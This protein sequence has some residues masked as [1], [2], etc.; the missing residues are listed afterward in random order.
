M[1]HISMNRAAAILKDCDGLLIYT[2][3]NP[4]GD[5]L[6]SA[7]A[8]CLALREMGKR[9]L[10]FSVDGIPQRLDFLPSN[11]LFLEKEPSD[12]SNYTPISVDVAGPRM[13]ESAENKSFYLSIDHHKVN[14]I[15]CENLLV[16]D[17][18]IACGEIIFEIID[19]LGVEFS[20][21]MAVAIYAAISSD[22]G[23]FRYEATSAKTHRMAARLHECGIDFAEINRRLFDSKT[24]AQVELTKAAYQSLELL[25]NGRLAIVAIPPEV[26][27]ACGAS[28]SDF[29]CINSVPREI[30]GV[31]ASAVIRQKGDGVKVS[32]RSNADIDVA[33]ISKQNGGGGHYHAAGFTFDGSFD[34]ALSLVRKIFMEIEI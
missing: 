25:R 18:R 9:A 30:A 15:D 5:T 3:A 17:D 11:G 7:I 33:E 10:I 29:D 1:E 13:L 24:K 21:D 20:K 34:D 31:L 28:D 2:H 16:C 14:T 26:A 19:E 6:G 12:L 22:S 27:N 32:F 8:L 4:D 23:G